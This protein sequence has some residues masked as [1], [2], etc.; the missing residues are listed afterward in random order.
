[1]ISLPGGDVFKAVL[2]APVH[3]HYLFLGKFCFL[4]VLLGTHYNYAKL[5]KI[6]ATIL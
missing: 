5:I 4:K 1:M 2:F 3:N 6:W